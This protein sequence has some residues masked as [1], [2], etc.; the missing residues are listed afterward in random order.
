M[1]ATESLP[2]C[3]P[4]R[5]VPANRFLS[6]PVR[7]GENAGAVPG[8]YEYYHGNAYLSLRALSLLFAGTEKAFHLTV[9]GEGYG[10][11]D[12]AA[13]GPAPVFSPD[14]PVPVSRCTC[15]DRN[16]RPV[17]YQLAAADDANGTRDCFVSPADLAMLLG[18]GVREE[19]GAIVFDPGQPFAADPEKLEADGFFTNLNAFLAADLTD[20]KILCGAEIYKPFAIASITKLMTAFLVYDEIEAGRLTWEE[21]V[22]VSPAGEE[23]S[24]SEDG[25]LPLR[26]GQR[27][28]TDELMRG[29]LVTSSNECALTLAERIAGS[30]K[31]FVKKMKE[32]AAELG[33]ES[34]EF[35]NSHGLPVFL[36][37]PFSAKLQN[38]MSAYDL[39]RF[40]SALLRKYP[41]I[42]K[43]T[44]RKET[45]LPVIGRTAHCTNAMLYNLEEA[46]GLKSGDTN[47]A[48]S[49][50]ITTLRKNGR[51]L[52]VVLLGAESLEDRNR[53]SEVLARYLLST[54]EP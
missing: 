30:E 15:F 29:M 10:V 40:V 48:G 2:L 11:E 18:V 33:L 42:T 39:F 12:G 38:R 26:A 20:G 43:I 6:F 46:T 23:Q 24:R 35:Y 52:A 21:A 53:K 50:L 44:S 9:T 13:G 17:K 37:C 7:V 14:A 47:R 1:N 34:A 16:G 19:N 25:M 3:A 28:P 49:C 4:D 32:K 22:T 41:E 45:R 27:I 5:F 51:D 36:S 31:A 8:F 54:C